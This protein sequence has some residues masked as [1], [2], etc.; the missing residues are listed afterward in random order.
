MRRLLIDRTVKAKI[1]I[2]VA[3]MLLA[4]V[5]IGMTG[6][7]KI[8]TLQDEHHR[9]LGQAVPYISALQQVATTA[10]AAAVDERGF[11]LS[12]EE[13]FSDEFA[14]RFTKIEENLDAARA[15]AAS[16]AQTTQVD[17]IAEGIGAWQD[18]VSAEFTRYATDEQGATEAALGPN[19]DLR[20]AYETELDAALKDA[21]EQLTA[22]TGFDETVDSARFLVILVL[23]LGIVWSLFNAVILTRAI[24]TPVRAV[25]GVLTR[26]AAGDLTGRAPVRSKDEL[27]QMAG[28]LNQAAEAMQTTVRTID[29]SSNSLAD[30]A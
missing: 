25:A 1:F 2:V 19:R 24:V 6:L 21:Q 12:G 17:E 16:P 26:M 4:G 15:A 14:E 5:A 27:G 9:Q 13:K 30:A 7:L 10:K 29:G 22:G 20:K 11:L 23:V 3:V 28:A 18:A 8:G